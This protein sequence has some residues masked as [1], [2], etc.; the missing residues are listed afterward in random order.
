M[1][2]GFKNFCFVFL[3]NELCTMW[4][5]TA[6]IVRVLVL[7]VPVLVLNNCMWQAVVW[8]T[9]PFHHSVIITHVTYYKDDHN[10]ITLVLLGTTKGF[11]N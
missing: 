11:V 4:E 8:S 3:D 9:S 2:G 7:Y 5:I 10:F 1:N 6:C